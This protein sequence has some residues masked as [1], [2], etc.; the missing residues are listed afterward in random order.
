MPDDDATHRRHGEPRRREPPQ[1][2]P[3]TR[4]RPP[5]A[6]TAHPGSNAC[7]AR[8]RHAHVRPAPHRIP[9]P[10]RTDRRVPVR[11][12]DGDHDHLAFRNADATDPDR[13]CREPLRRQHDRRVH[14][15]QFLHHSG[16]P[17][18][19]LPTPDRSTANEYRCRSGWP[20]SRG[21]P[22]AA[23]WRW[24]ATPA[25][26]SGPR[27]RWPRSARTAGRRPALRTSPRSASV[28]YSLA[29]GTPAGTARERLPAS[30]SSNPGKQSGPR[31]AR[32]AVR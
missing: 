4:P 16:H 30:P 10:A 19:H 13:L 6:P 14:P 7:R 28:R 5:T 15:Q 18:D 23:G 21:R 32:R 11:R 17:S 8:T 29:R 24:P 25:P 22:P 9:P 26:T 20:S 1:R 12:P 27:P 2:V 3:R 31:Q